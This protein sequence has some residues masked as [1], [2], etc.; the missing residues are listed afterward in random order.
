MLPNGIFVHMGSKSKELGVRHTN[1]ERPLVGTYAVRTFAPLSVV[2]GVRSSE[3]AFGVWQLAERRPWHIEV[4]FDASILQPH[5]HV[6][7]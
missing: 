1:R 3:F 5:C 7:R 4:Q 2:S 6:N